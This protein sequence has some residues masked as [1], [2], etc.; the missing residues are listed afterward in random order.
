M[1][2]SNSNMT[3]NIYSTIPTPNGIPATGYYAPPKNVGDLSFNINL[4]NNPYNYTI[5]GDAS[6]NIV[7]SSTNPYLP[8]ILPVYIP[9]LYSNVYQIQNNLVNTML[10]SALDDRLYPTT[11]AVAQYVASQ[12]SGYEDISGNDW[13]VSTN[14]TTSILGPNLGG[15]QTMISGS[16]SEY[17]YQLADIEKTRVGTEKIVICNAPVDANTYMILQA[18]EGS[19]S[20]NGY[21]I[22][23]GQP[24]TTYTFSQRG[25]MI[26]M[27]Q[28]FNGEYNVYFVKTYGGLFS[29][30]AII[31]I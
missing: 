17:V 14:V 12:I 22:V 21:F 5:I 2:N 3:Q 24:Y 20:V 29:N 31:N 9:T 26:D 7:G 16:V 30:N 13:I 25:D 23:L 1:S 8:A 4:S 6:S 27:V 19:S 11:Y 10:P 15:Q 18:N 28:F